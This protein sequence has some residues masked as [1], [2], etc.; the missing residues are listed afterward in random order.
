MEFDLK[1]AKDDI[2]R[3]AK[4]LFVGGSSAL[5]ELL[6]FQLLY[7]VLGWQIAVANISAVIIATAYNFLLNRSW[8]FKQDKNA[9]RSILLYLL[10]FAF[11][12]TF[13]TTAISLLVARSISSVIAKLFTQVCIVLWNY[14]LYK[15]VIFK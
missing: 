14:V 11:N 7:A 13:S 8:A 9:A 6:L 12:T 5:L 3:I 1:L 4:Y 15:R 2:V 10:L